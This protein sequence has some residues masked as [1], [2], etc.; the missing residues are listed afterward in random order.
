[1]LAAGAGGVV[2]GGLAGDEGE[3]SG[4][5]QADYQGHKQC[6]EPLPSAYGPVESVVADVE[7]V[8]LGLAER[9]V[10]GGIGADPSSGS[11][12]CLQQAAA[13]EVGR[14]A[15][16]VCPLGGGGAQPGADDPVGVGVGEPGVAQQRPGGQQRL[17][18]EFHGA[19]GEGE[20]PFGGEGL[21]HR[22]H[23]L[24]LG[25][26][27]ACGQLRPAGAV[28]GVHPLGAGGGQPGED[29]PGGGLLAGGKS[30]VGALR[31]A[32]D[33]AFDAAGAFVV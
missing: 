21:K 15:G 27:S 29:L 13:V 5:G 14:V 16:V 3:G 12:R 17:V 20:Q 8:T 28:G 4:R 1:M 25:G 11:G 23:I 33:R 19:G 7:E 24:E 2:H 30:L 6:D 18:T 31:A 26:A 22:L 10:A 9:R 32:G